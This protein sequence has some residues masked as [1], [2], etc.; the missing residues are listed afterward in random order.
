MFSFVY[1]RAAVLRVAN[2]SLKHASG[3]GKNKKKLSS[4][5]TGVTDIEVTGPDT[6][7]EVCDFSSIQHVLQV[8]L[9]NLT[10]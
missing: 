3:V 5:L 1:E 9:Q 4:C 7:Q 10:L 2:F 6:P 8:L